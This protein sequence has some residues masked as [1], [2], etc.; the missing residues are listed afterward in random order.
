MEKDDR[1]FIILAALAAM[2]LI[3]SLENQPAR[4]FQQVSFFL[5]YGILA[6]LIYLLGTN[7]VQAIQQ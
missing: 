5:S 1:R 6:Y 7:L 4:W 2:I 3:N